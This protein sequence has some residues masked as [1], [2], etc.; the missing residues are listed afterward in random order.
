M[1]YL[2]VLEFPNKFFSLGG[3]L[4]SALSTTYVKKDAT[5]LLALLQ[6]HQYSSSAS[7]LEAHIQATKPQA[8]LQRNVVCK[9]APHQPQYCN[10]MLIKK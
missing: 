2:E 4:V 10:Y 6:T 7:K 5:P 3:W 1:G 8:K 9:S